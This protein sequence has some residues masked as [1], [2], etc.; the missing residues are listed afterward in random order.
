MVI[1]SD[2]ASPKRFWY[3]WDSRAYDVTWRPNVLFNTNRILP[4]CLPPV[5]MSYCPSN[6]HQFEHSWC[7]WKMSLVKT[8]AGV[9]HPIKHPIILVSWNRTQSCWAFQRIFEDQEQFSPQIISCFR[10][11]FI[12]L[13][14][15][16]NIN[17]SFRSIP[18]PG[19]TSS[20][21]GGKSL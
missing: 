2:V 11:E 20:G 7:H 18:L 21:N 10:L 14:Q 4:A 15:R 6:S 19:Q 12:K 13:P 3:L 5:C 1:S 9:K 16:E 8:V 17:S